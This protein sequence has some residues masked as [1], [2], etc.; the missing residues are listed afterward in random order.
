MRGECDSATVTPSTTTRTALLLA[1]MGVHRLILLEPFVHS[2]P[3]EPDQVAQFG[4]RRVW[5]AQRRVLASLAGRHHVE[6]A[7][8]TTAGRVL[9]GAGV[10]EGGPDVG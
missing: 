2:G 1:R 10:L 4:N 5:I 8:V 3:V 9:D 6:N 7:P